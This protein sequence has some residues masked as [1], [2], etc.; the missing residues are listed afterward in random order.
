MPGKPEM[1]PRLWTHFDRII[2]QQ[3][4]L[5]APEDGR[6]VRALRLAAA[7]ADAGDP[8]VRSAAPAEIH[9]RSGQCGARAAVSWRQQR[10]DGPGP[11]PLHPNRH[12]D[13][14]GGG[15]GSIPVHH[16]DPGATPGGVLCYRRRGMAKMVEY[17]SL[18]DAARDLP[19]RSRA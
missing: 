12:F 6:R 2:L 5:G 7:V 9:A 13:R 19:R 11:I 1:P 18:A 16:F 8:A 4:W 3:N 10:W 17:T 15:G 14:V